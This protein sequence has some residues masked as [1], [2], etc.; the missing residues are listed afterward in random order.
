MACGKTDCEYFKAQN[1]LQCAPPTHTVHYAIQIQC[2]ANIV[3]VFGSCMHRSVCHQSM[4]SE[5]MHFVAFTIII[6][7]TIISWEHT[8][9]SGCVSFG[10]RTNVDLELI[11]DVIVNWMCNR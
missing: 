4:K 2:V 8:C 7:M 10:K 11:D 1:A 3:R 9:I 5:F 6:V